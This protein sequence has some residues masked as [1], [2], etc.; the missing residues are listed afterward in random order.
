MR[1]PETRLP[2][3]ESLIHPEIVTWCSHGRA[4]IMH[5]P[6]IFAAEIMGV[7]FKQSKLTSFQRQLNLYGFRRIT[8]GVDAGAYYHELFLRGR[9]Q[10]CMRMQRQ[11][12]KGVGH[13]QPTDVSTEPNFY[14]MKPLPTTSAT[15]Q[16]GNISMVMEEVAVSVGGSD[17]PLFLLGKGAIP[18]G[19]LQCRKT[20]G[21]N[22]SS[23]SDE[24]STYTS[25][26]A[27][28]LRRLS[29]SQVTAPPP[30]ASAKAP[31][32][33]KDG[34]KEEDTKMSSV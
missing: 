26:A 15:T 23:I 2:C 33:S 17:V 29:T 34:K 24:A 25:E 12:V 14:A 27:S 22:P 4:F 30:L 8:Q 11:K 5:K 3:K 19:S 10:L 16:R 28:M 21:I 7:Y 20:T 9:H 6:K 32:S 31:P 1:W 18:D 13:K